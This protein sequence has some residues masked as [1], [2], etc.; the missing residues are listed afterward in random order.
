[1]KAVIKVQSPGRNSVVLWVTGIVS[2][3]EEHTVLC[4]SQ[5]KRHCEKSHE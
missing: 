4:A 5:T 2:M 3:R 1:M